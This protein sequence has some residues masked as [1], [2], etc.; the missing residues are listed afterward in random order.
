MSA[1]AGRARP[2][3]VRA[4]AAVGEHA[5]RTPRRTAGSR[6]PARATSAWVSAGSTGPDSRAAM[7]RAV[8][9]VGRAAP[10]RW[11]RVAQP[12]APARLAAR[13]ARAGPRRPPG[14]A[15]PGRPLHAGPPGTRTRRVRPVQVLDDQDQRSAG[16]DRSGT[17]A[18]RP[19]TRSRVGRP[20]RPGRRAAQAA[21]AATRAR[22]GPRHLRIG[23]SSLT[24]DGAG[25]SDSRI[26][27]WALTISPRAQ[28]VMPSP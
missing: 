25:S 1:L 11:R 26:P 24:D 2:A 14:G 8:S 9:V 22:W 7:S 12:T 4:D 3:A 28:N 10:G 13:A 5:A 23:P 16:G 18:R 6:R 21:L 15:T 20:P 19:R 27:A 17:A